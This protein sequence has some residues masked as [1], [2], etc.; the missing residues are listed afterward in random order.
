MN[1]Q[2]GEWVKVKTPEQIAETLNKDGKN[3]GLMVTT[4]MLS[5]CG[6]AFRV[7]KRL[8]KMI[9]EPTRKLI[10]V[11]NTV[12]L[13]NALCDGCHILRGGCPRGNYHFWREIWLERVRPTHNQ[14]V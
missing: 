11:E 7:L 6:A 9:H 3:R 4:E 14:T 12:I 5:F 10:D 8:N 13:E 1:L 2:P